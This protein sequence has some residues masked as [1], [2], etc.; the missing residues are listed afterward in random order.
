MAEVSRFDLAMERFDHSLTK[1]KNRDAQ[2]RGDVQRM[3]M[4]AAE[5]NL[6]QADRQKLARELEMLK[7]KAAEL[8]DTSRQAAGKIDSAMARIRS[9]LHSNSGA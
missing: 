1:F 6:L 8:V 2:K 4:L 7:A 3:Q 9:V 5:A